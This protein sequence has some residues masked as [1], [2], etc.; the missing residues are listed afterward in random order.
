VYENLLGYGSGYWSVWAC[1]YGS[2]YRSGFGYGFYG[3]GIDKLK[4]DGIVFKKN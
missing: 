3:Y 2:G 1:V 4:N